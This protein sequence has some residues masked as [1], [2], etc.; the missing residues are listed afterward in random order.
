MRHFA[1]RVTGLDAIAERLRAANVPFTVPPTNANGG[2]R[3]AF[4]TDPDGTLIELI[5]GELT[6]SRR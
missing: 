5:E 2:V 6:Y 3:I 4:F 1:L